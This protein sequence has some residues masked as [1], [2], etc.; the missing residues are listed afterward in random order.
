MVDVGG[1]ETLEIDGRTRDCVL[2]QAYVGRRRNMTYFYAPDRSV[3]RVGGPKELL[4]IRAS[5]KEEAQK[6]FD[7]NI[8]TEIVPVTH[9]WPAEDYHQRYFEKHPGH[10]SCHYI[11]GWV[12]G[13]EAE[14]PKT[15]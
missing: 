2:V 10:Y 11:R 13:E 5:T 4:S 6:F 1:P 3:L 14:T 7:R 12:P 9:F 15:A 8:V